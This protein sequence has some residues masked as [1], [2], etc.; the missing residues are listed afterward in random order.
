MS[1]TRVSVLVP[2]LGQSAELPATLEAVEH[3]DLEGKP[4][5]LQVAFDR[6]ERGRQLGR[7]SKQRD[8]D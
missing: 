8:K 4:G 2:L 1:A 7:L 5:R 3:A 6:F